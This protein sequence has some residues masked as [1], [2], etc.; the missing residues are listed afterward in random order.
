MSL[1]YALLYGICR[2]LAFFPLRCLYLFSD[3]FYVIACY[4]LH[5]RRAVVMENLQNAFPG[6]TEKERKKIARQFYHFL[7]DLIFESI[8]TLN[9]SAKEMQR[10]IHFSTPKLLDE[11][12][13]KGKQVFFA[14][15][16]YGNWEW[17]ATLEP[18]DPYHQAT[19]YRPLNNKAF[20]KLMYRIR[21]GFGTDAVPTNQTIR[22]I[23]QFINNKL[24]TILCFLCDQSPQ[25]DVIQYWTNF[26]NQD[27]PVFL[28]LEKLARRYNAAVM[29]FEVRRVKRGYY[30][31]DTTLITENAAETEPYEITERHTALLEETIR[32]NPQYWL[33]SH[34]RWKHKK[35]YTN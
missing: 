2:F 22:Y 26:L 5:Y 3:F 27:T 35:V 14:T 10:R 15:G 12:Y 31:V 7:C 25:K 20:D 19:L 4:I 29:Y 28:G 11:L 33:W 30:L 16:H 24:L 8:K 18:I 1:V 9:I 17:L 34:R 23:N 13:R 6:K 32:R 21:T